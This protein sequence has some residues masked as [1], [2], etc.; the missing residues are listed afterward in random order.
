MRRR[1]RRRRIVS[2]FLGLIVFE[3]Y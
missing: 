1:I 3:Y 2:Q